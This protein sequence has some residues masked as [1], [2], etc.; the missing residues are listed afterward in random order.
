VCWK[1]KQRTLAGK[2]PDWWS[3]FADLCEH[4]IGTCCDVSDLMSLDLGWNGYSIIASGHTGTPDANNID[5][6]D[7]HSKIT[8]NQ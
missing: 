5:S 7:N 4:P 8:R 1:G 6:I 2:S 3:V